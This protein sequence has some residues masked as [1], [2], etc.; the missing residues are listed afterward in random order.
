V[1]DL[2]NEG[3]ARARSAYGENYA[4]LAEVKR[5][6]DAANFFRVNQNIKP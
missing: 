6:Y 2:E 5:K 1:N 4:R 3:D